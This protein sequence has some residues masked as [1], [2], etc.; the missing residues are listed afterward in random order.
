MNRRGAIGLL[1]GVILLIAA[2]TVAATRPIE[3]EFAGRPVVLPDVL[4]EGGWLSMLIPTEYG[5]GGASLN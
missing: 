1:S 4:Q 5:G 3:A 2:W